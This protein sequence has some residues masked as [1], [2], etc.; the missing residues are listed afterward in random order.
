MINSISSDQGKLNKW[1]IDSAGNIAISPSGVALLGRIKPFM[2]PFFTSTEQA[3]EWGSHLN[4]EQHATLIDIHRTASNA[5]LSE[6]N[7]Q[8]MVNLA[9]QLQLM[10]EAI[11]AAPSAG[12]R[13]KSWARGGK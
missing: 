1:L 4:D 3:V 13:G 8:L 9:T 11:E 12:P 10:R 2:V 5:G 7:L 6:P